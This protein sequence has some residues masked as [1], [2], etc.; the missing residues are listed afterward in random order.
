MNFTQSHQN[1]L[2]TID[3][4]QL[5]LSIFT[6]REET[7]FSIFILGVEENVPGRGNRAV[8]CNSPLEFQLTDTFD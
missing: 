8:I 1:D 5:A 4:F 3:V 2:L 7:L 6:S